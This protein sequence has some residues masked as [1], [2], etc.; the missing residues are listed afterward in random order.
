MGQGGMRLALL[1]F[2]CCM[3]LCNA[4]W[5]PYDHN[6][7]VSLYSHKCNIE[8]RAQ[9][10]VSD[11]VSTY[12]NTRT[13][14]IIL[15]DPSTNA[16]FQQMCQQDYLLQFYPNVTVTLSTAN[17][18]SYKKKKVKLGK[19][20][21]EMVG[22]QRESVNGVKTFILF[23]DT[24]ISDLSSLLTKY[25]Q[26][27]YFGAIEPSLS[28]GIAG[29]GTGVPFHRHGAV[30]NEVIHGYKRWFLYPPDIEPQFDG[31]QTTLHWLK[32][33][34]PVQALNP[35]MQECV[36][37]PNEVLYVP[38]NWWHATLN[39]GQTVNIATFV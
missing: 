27:Q 34:Y 4:E 13:P 16:V 26:P 18:F 36:L 37:G 24:D 11:F 8:R 35:I 30:F 29:S 39:V 14:V 10:S 7:S 5:A 2:A 17:T 15:R 33:L 28:W 31:T 32:T 19:Y 6:A 38:E 9:L 21:N 23:G 20:I 1:L 25:V 22:D 12:K 3:C